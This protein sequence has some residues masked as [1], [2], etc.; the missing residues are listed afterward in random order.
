MRRF[1]R[2]S[3]ADSLTLVDVLVGVVV[4]LVLVGLICSCGRSGPSQRTMCLSKLKQIAVALHYYCTDYDQYFPCYPAYGSDPQSLKGEHWNLGVYADPRIEEAVRTGN[5]EY[6]A[7]PS[8]YRCVFYGSRFTDRPGFEMPP[9]ERGRLNVAPIGLG[10]L[11][12]AGYM[13]DVRILFCPAARRV[14]KMEGYGALTE[15][16]EL[17]RAGGFNFQELSRG[18]YAWA[19]SYYKGQ[20]DRG[21]L[22]SYNYRNVPLA[23]DPGAKL[24]KGGVEVPYT[25]PAV[26]AQPGLSH[27]QDAE[28]PR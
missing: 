10:Y 25:A 8:R 27:V 7:G 1:R 28:A 13:G 17:E 6:Y 11:A 12:E 15:I 24:T 20:S 23:V 21:V 5:R 3:F 16:D 9:F 14:P 26:Y 18:D 19:D 2:A 4:V 22:S